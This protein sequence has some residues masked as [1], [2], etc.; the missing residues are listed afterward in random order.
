MTPR[1]VKSIVKAIEYEHRQLELK[2]TLI[3][4]GVKFYDKLG[5][6]YM[7]HPQK[8]YVEVWDA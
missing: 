7:N 2:A 8:N 1:E 6:G 3:E 4:K 5:W